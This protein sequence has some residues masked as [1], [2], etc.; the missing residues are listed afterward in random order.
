MPFVVFA[1][2]FLIMRNILTDRARHPMRAVFVMMATVIAG[3]WS[4]MSGTA[5][6][7]VLHAAGLL[8]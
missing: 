1:A 7:A 5:V 3:F 8:A 4:L 6:V 2:P